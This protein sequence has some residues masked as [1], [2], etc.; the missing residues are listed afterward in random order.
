MSND[1]NIADILREHRFMEKNFYSPIIGQC[2]LKGIDNNDRI[3]LHN[4]NGKVCLWQNGK[5]CNDEHAKLM[6]FPSLEMT[7]WSKFFKR[8]DIVIKNGGDMSAIFD[9]WANDAYT[10]FNTTINL[11]SD[12]NTGE[13][14]VCGTSLF[15]KATEDERKQFIEK[16]EG[17]FKGKYSSK[18]LQVE[19]VKPK[20]P[21]KPFDK[22]LVRDTDT[23]KWLPGFFDKFNENGDYP[24]HILNFHNMNDFAYRYCI[25]YEGNERLLGT[26]EPY[27][28]TS[29]KL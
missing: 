20:C 4:K 2:E 21:F 28:K 24:Y 12:G 14:E 10:E 13:E 22:V 16:I 5:F 7:D 6:I 18:T 17:I 3:V 1:I 8:G 29:I 23:N 19:P 9:G 26:T 15:R 27:N 25:P 11:Y